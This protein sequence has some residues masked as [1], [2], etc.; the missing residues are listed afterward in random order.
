MVAFTG[1]TVNGAVAEHLGVLATVLELYDEADGHFGHA[2]QTYEGLS[3]PFFVAMTELEWGRM[4][5]VR[6]AAG[7]LTRARTMLSSARGTAQRYG[8]A[9]LERRVGEELATLS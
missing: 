2:L 5:L 4:L 7:D 8:F 1:A 3:A 6:R 9:G